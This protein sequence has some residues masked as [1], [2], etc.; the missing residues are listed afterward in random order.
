ML[1]K[2]EL[3]AATIAKRNQLTGFDF[4]L[5]SRLVFERAHKIKQ[6]QLAQRVHVYVATGNE[7]PSMAFIEYALGIG[8]EVYVPV[9]VAQNPL[10]QHV[11]VFWHTQWHSGAYG[12][13]EPVLNES[14]VYQNAEYFDSQ[15]AI[16]VPVV[17]F[18][19]HCN[20]LGYGKGYYDRFLSNTQATRLGIAYECQLVPEIPAEVHDVPLHAV[21]TEERLY[22]RQ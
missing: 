9:V 16:I 11:Q 3:R 5:K 14:S 7:V 21:A 6:F 12:I 17:A 10:L 1:T 18:D 2:N 13:Q 20:R 8:K 4:D 19:K 15:S 22:V